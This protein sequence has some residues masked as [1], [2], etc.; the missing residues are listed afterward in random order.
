MRLK[1]VIMAILLLACCSL[2]IAFDDS[3]AEGDSKITVDPPVYEGSTGDLIYSGTASFGIVNLRVRSL[4]DDGYLSVIDSCI[5]EGGKYSGRVH[6]GALVDGSYELRVSY[7]SDVVIEHFLVSSEEFV[8]ILNASYSDGLLKY[9]GETNARLVNAVFYN[10]QYRSVIIASLPVDGRFSEVIDLGALPSGDYFLKVKGYAAESIVSVD[11]GS[12]HPDDPFILSDDGKILLECRVTDGS[13]FILPD[14]V[15]EVAEDAFRKS[16]IGRLVLNRDVIWDTSPKN[17]LFILQ[18]AGVTEIEI[19]GDVTSIPDYLFACTDIKEITIPSSIGIIGAKSFY[20]C[21][22]LKSIVFEGDSKI[23]TVGIY[24]FSNNR[25]LKSVEFGSSA[26]GYSCTLEKGSFFNDGVLDT[27]RVDPRFNLYSIGDGCFALC[28]SFSLLMGEENGKLVRIPGTV[29]YLGTSAFGYAVSSAL[30]QSP[31]PGRGTIAGFN[32]YTMGSISEKQSEYGLVF[33]P[34]SQLTKINENCFSGVPFNW[35]DLTGCSVLETVDAG[36]F[37]GCLNVGNCNISFSSSMRTIRDGAF[38]CNGNPTKASIT[39]ESRIVIPA[40]VEYVGELAFMGLSAIISFE[41]SSRLGTLLR[42]S[43]SDTNRL[44][45]VSN[46]L[47]LELLGPQESNLRFPVGVVSIKYIG[48]KAEEP[49]E[50]AIVDKNVLRITSATKTILLNCDNFGVTTYL[51]DGIRIDCDPANKYFNYEDGLLTLDNGVRKKVVYISNKTHVELGAAVEDGTQVLRHSLSDSVR[52]L[53]LSNPNIVIESSLTKESS[54]LK[55]VFITDNPNSWDIPSVFSEVPAGVSF[56]VVPHG[57]SAPYHSNG[58]SADDI[59]FLASQGEVYVGFRSGEHIVYYPTSYDGVSINIENVVDHDGTGISADISYSKTISDSIEFLAIGACSEY[60][61]DRITIHDYGRDPT[62][63]LKAIKASSAQKNDFTVYFDGNGGT[64]SDGMTVQ[65][66]KIAEGSRLD[67]L[68]IPVFNKPLSVANGW[69]DASGREFSSDSRVDR[70]LVL[71][72]DWIARGPIVTI[73]QTSAVTYVNGRGASSFEFAGEAVELIA[74]PKSGYELQNWLVDGVSKGP[75]SKPLVLNDIVTDTSVSIQYRYYSISS[76]L[77]P[78]VETG[79]LTT[80]EMNDLVKTYILGGYVDTSMATWTGTSSVP[81]IVGDYIYLRIAESL[82]KIESDTGHV[83]K[84]V[85]SESRAAFYH[86]V[87]YGGGVIIDYHT[88]KAYDLDLNQLYV[89]SRP[90]SG[91]EYHN[92]MFYTSG[93][94]VY[95]F[96]PEDEDPNSIHEIKRLE[97]VGTI[98]GTYSSYGFTMSCFVDNY[99]YRVTAEGTNR[100]LAAMDLDT[101][102]VKHRP[103]NSLSYL[104]L[105]DGWIS[106]YNGY[107]FLTGYT[108]GLFGASASDG[109]AVLAYVPVNGLDFGEERHLEF[110]KAFGGVDSRSFTSQFVVY[111]NRGFVNASGRLY[112]FELPEDLSDLDLMKLEKRSIDFGLGHGSIVLDV[113]H[114]SKEGSPIYVYTIPYDTHYSTTLSV[115]KDCAGELTKYDLYT[116]AREWNSQAVRSDA[117]GRLMWYNDSGWIHGYTTSDRNDY[118]FFI[119]DGDSAKWYVASGADAAD[120]LSSLG[121]DVVTL[122][123]AKVIQTLNGHEASDVRLEMLK[124]RYGTTDSKKDHYN[125]L[126]QYSWESISNLGE[127]S[128]SL[129]HYFR[130]VSGRDSPITDGEVYTYIDDEGEKREYRFVDNIGNRNIIGKQLA[131]GRSDETVVLT[132]SEDGIELPG[133]RTVVR[134]G[135]VSKILFPEVT[136]VGYVPVWKDDSGEE[137]KDSNAMILTS[138]ASFQLTWNDVPPYYVVS[139]T[140]TAADG[141]T[142]WSADIAVKSGVGEVEGLR[143]DV[144]AVSTEGIVLSGTTVTASD[145]SAQGLF[146]TDG[147]SV[148]YIRVVDEHVEGN[149]GYVMI[150]SEAGP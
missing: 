52:T 124:A 109:V 149:R 81:L 54:N 138:N 78:I 17:N 2:M 9:D 140:M 50:V 86:Q 48:L 43:T 107:L 58:I 31:E 53:Y 37:N 114:S 40:S 95:R 141:K 90:V 67:S 11:V 64:T 115:A 75:A 23:E 46:C 1:I 147:I 110:N 44:I 68:N 99:M 18:N 55:S 69:R 79:M 72:Q 116:T 89:L 29:G 26:E 136:K 39:D 91:V 76:G 24:A 47:D 121:T 59:R 36:A 4:N 125:N 71:K 60:A 20:N 77:N 98:D 132:F 74:K 105:D 85:D 103:L 66:F 148:I 94:D 19:T 84:R 38:K 30:P 32:A 93:K 16:N 120:A 25:S 113:S 108:Q 14:T 49:S 104:F 106:Y 123:A 119:E 129:N 118:F 51:S 122:N 41:E 13:G 101:G 135:S 137:V 33:E 144:T 87:G 70:N 42:V 139:G 73:D 8:S 100:G 96:S 22:D 112:V 35:I 5:V 88:S 45:D 126:D 97:K 83:V 34:N 80:E 65:S 143:L 12:T 7:G 145:G 63:I 131:R 133:T 6:L 56:Y 3:A 27:V 142:N 82:Y 102:V 10:N 21:R 146:E 92:G 57:P 117:D 128:Y 130:I 28:G 134:S 62:I 15:E 150:E 127:K 61:D 111:D